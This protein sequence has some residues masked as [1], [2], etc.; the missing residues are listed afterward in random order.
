MGVSKGG[1][2]MIINATQY[3]GPCACKTTHRVTTQLAVIEA[4]CLTEFDRYAREQ[5]LLGRRAAIYDENTY[6]AEGLL[7]PHA[8]QELILPAANLRADERTANEALGALRADTQVLIA[9]GGGTVHDI[10][11][12]C[13]TKLGLPFIAC[14]TAAS[15]VGFASNRCAMAWNG[16]HRVVPGVAPLLVL[17]DVNVLARAP[18]H[19][20]RGGIGEALGNYTALTDW[21]IAQLLTGRALC[22]AA[23]ALALQAAVAAQGCCGRFARGDGDAVAQLMY[24]LLLSGLAAQILGDRHPAV[25]A[26]H[27]LCH[28]M[29]LL[30]EDRGP[31]SDLLYGERVGAASVAIAEKYHH[32]GSMQNIAPLLVN[33]APIDRQWLSDRFG[34]PLADA[35]LEKNEPDC[36]AT[37][38]PDLL[39]ARWTSIRRVIAELPTAEALAQLLCQ[40]QG[41]ENEDP[42]APGIPDKRLPELLEM[43]PYLENQPTLLRML[44]LLALPYGQSADASRAASRSKRYAES[45]ITRAGSRR[46]V[47]A[48]SMR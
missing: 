32:V 46:A 41:K 27:H 13:A 39:A 24:A 33:Y 8:E 23:E 45:A 18:R 34:A 28:A 36:L 11:R 5:G 29:G 19:L 40:A 48:S 1:M 10:A 6:H 14:P 21:R 37:I 16:A 17:A 2:S 9:V 43:A 3:V 44:R 7:R 38:N 22:P 26:E 35:L 47:S 15:G 4:G 31:K 12:Y 25:G 30:P 20:A 42:K